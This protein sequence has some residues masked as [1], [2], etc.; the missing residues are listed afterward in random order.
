MFVFQKKN[1]LIIK[2]LNKIFNKYF[3]KFEI[4]S[5]INFQKNMPVNANGKLDKNKLNQKIKR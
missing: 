3:E 5:S 2:R 1:N 4:P